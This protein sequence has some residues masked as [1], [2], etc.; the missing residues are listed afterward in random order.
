M[1]NH[2]QGIKLCDVRKD[3]EAHPNKQEEKNYE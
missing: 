3:R 1:P 2:T